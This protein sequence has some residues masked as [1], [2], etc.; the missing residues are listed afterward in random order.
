MRKHSPLIMGIAFFLASLN[1][2][3]AINSV[4]PILQT[5]R[6]DLGMS[7]F[8]ASLLTSLPVLCM[9]LFSPLAVS[10][11]RRFGLERM[12]GWSLAVIGLGNALR[13]ATHSAFAM[14]ATALLAGIGIAAIGPLLSGFIKSRFPARVPAMVALYT[15]A[16]ALGATAASGLSIPLQHAL[17]SWQYALALWAVL[18]LFAFAVWR[19]AVPQPA[20]RPDNAQAAVVAK[21]PWRSG[22]AWLLT[23]SF[24]ALAMLF[25]SV[26]A[27][28]PP[29]VQ[30]LGFGKAYAANMLTL[31]SITQVPVSLILSMLLKRVP[32]RLVWLFVGSVFLLT[33]FVLLELSAPPWIAVVL[34]GIG[35]G[36]LFP[37][38][39][40]LPIDASANAH[41]AAA[42]S[43]MTQ[44][45]GYVIG[46]FGPILLGWLYDAA[47]GYSAV[48]IAGLIVVTLAMIGIHIV[49]VRRREAKSRS[50]TPTFGYVRQADS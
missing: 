28:L 1:L 17:H 41:E 40:M 23:L 47:G 11:G 7:A 38:N 20:P 32:S 45:A 10:W 9:G 5:L 13:I 34:I 21:L 15:I 22:E 4:S 35:P 26:T 30:D 18:A 36:L 6:H 25:F 50:G 14:L 16:L 42:W 37:I 33:G 19:W 31:F 48:L 39:L 8:T 27:W 46:A 24:G 12:I 29:V 44:S 49:I 43:A 2:R 3:P